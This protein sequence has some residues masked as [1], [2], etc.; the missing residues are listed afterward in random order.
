M[1]G[2]DADAAIRWFGATEAGNFVD[3]HHP[4]L[5]GRNVLEDAGPRPGNAEE[6]RTRLRLARE[7]RTWPGLD[8]KRLAAWNALAIAAFA[9][10]GAVLGR[11][12]Y[13][14]AA[15]G[16]A[17]F[18][19]ER[20]TDTEGR[21]LRSFNA[22]EARLP[23]YLEDH[24]FLLE[25]LLV[26]YEATF[27]E[28]WFLAARGLADTLLA[29]FEDPEH[30]G[31]FSTAND[32]EELF[33]RRKDLEDA[34]IPAGGS[35][36]ALGLLRLAGLTG[37]HR[38]EAAAEGQLRLLHVLAP[39]HPTAS[40]HL[41]QALD[42]RLGPRREVAI[43]GPP[44]AR[45]PLVAAV[46]AT[47]RPGVVLAGGSGEEAGAVPL[48]EGRSAPELGASAYVC[49]DFACRRPVGTPDDLCGALDGALDGAP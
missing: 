10:A 5:T 26:L 3:P 8:D 16:A 23:A 35:S 1:L 32:H 37:E 6:I 41:L 12:D 11:E 29:R 47:L 34:P 33:A 48:L 2:A 31:F 30:G 43:V 40:G 14:D 28:R 21:L 36:A 44:E 45:A 24:A 17:A 27:E 7:Q 13:L 20:M 49:Q 18:V 19:L 25:A 22:G 9:D 42:E 38:Y 4:E 46:R 39:Q 15:R